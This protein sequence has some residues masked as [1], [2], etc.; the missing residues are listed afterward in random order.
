MRTIRQRVNIS[1]DGVRPIQFSVGPTGLDGENL[2]MCCDD[3]ETC[4]RVRKGRPPRQARLQLL[5]VNGPMDRLHIDLCGPFPRSD[6]K[7]YILT[8][9]DAFTRYLTVAALPNKKAHTVAEALVRF[10]FCILGKPRQI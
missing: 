6:W 9:V 8:C 5:Y 7:I 4:V 1:D 10:T 2:W 3:C